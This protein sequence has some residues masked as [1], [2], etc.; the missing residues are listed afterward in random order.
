[1]EHNFDKDLKQRL[2]NTSLPEAG[3]SFDKDKLWGKI[4]NKKNKKRIPFLSWATHTAAVAAGLAIGIFFFTRANK[5]EPATLNVVAQK[6]NQQVTTTI[7]DTVYL[8]QHESTSQKQGQKTTTI[9]RL[10]QEQKQPQ[11]TIIAQETQPQPE[12]KTMPEPTPV[13]VFAMAQTKQVKV[14]HLSDMGNENAN[15][16]VTKE[17]KS[18]FNIA[19]YNS[20]SSESGVE[21]F[22][23]LI[24]QKLNLTRN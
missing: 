3:L 13:P 4:E 6:Q 20:A 2:D 1:M 18:I 14:L 5:E 7:T 11:K 24:A 12:Q 10:Q 15:H 22:T 8:A 9:T 16:T 21:T 19:Q 23:A 17:K